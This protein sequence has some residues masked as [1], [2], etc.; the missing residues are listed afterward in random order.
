MADAGDAVALTADRIG[1]KARL[2]LFP[3][4]RP[5]LSPNW[6]TGRAEDCADDIN[7]SE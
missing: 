3:L 6:R 2:T 5:G 4:G 1:E 7:P